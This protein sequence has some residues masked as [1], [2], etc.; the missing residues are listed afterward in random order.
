MAMDAIQTSSTLWTVSRVGAPRSATLTAATRVE[1]KAA[2][3][4][5]PLIA[6]ARTGAAVHIDGSVG[7][8]VPIRSGASATRVSRMPASAMLRSAA[9]NHLVQLAAFATLGRVAS[10]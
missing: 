6:K 4:Q 5:P 7:G 8:P 10:V 1:A 2:Q 3:R 9:R